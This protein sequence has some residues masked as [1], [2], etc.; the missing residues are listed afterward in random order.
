MVQRHVLLK[1]G[2]LIALVMVL[3]W[4]A[5]VL[6]LQSLGDH[7][8][9]ERALAVMLLIVF[10][11]SS[12]F[13]F[14]GVVVPLTVFATLY[15]PV[16]RDYGVPSYQYVVS[17]LATDAEEATEFLSLFSLKTW[18]LTLLLPVTV[19]TFWKVFR[20]SGFDPC[21]V[22]PLIIATV[23]LMI[24]VS[25]PTKFIDHVKEAVKYARNDQALVVGGTSENLWGGVKRNQNQYKNYVLVIG[26]SARRD[27]FHVYGYPI[28]NTPF[29]DSVKGMVVDGL[30]AGDVYTVGSLRLMLTKAKVQTREPDYARTVVGL[31]KAGG[32]ATYWFSNQGLTGN[33]DS[34]VAAIALQSEKT[35]FTKTGDYTIG[36][37]S[38][39]RLLKPL[40][41]ALADNELRSRFIVLHT[42]GS[43]PHACERV[44]DWPAKTKTSVRY[45][46]VACYSDSIAK[47]DQFLS[48]V[49]EALKAQQEK[50]GEAF[51]LLYFSDHGLSHYEKNGNVALGNGNGGVSRYQCDIPLVRINS[52][53]VVHRVVKSRKTGLLFTDGLGRWLGLS[54]PELQPYDLF[55][56]VEDVGDYGFGSWMAAKAPK[57]D[58]ALDIRPYVRGSA[59]V[60]F[61]DAA[62]D[63]AIP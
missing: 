34:P 43:H 41:Q 26:E 4:L 54:A 53:D 39:T 18:L 22:K 40:R 55:D 42:M 59:S 1:K 7:V 47:T 44:V 35:I 17:L 46:N 58:P 27:Y 50:T 56:G 25:K 38:D 28:A 29:L 51:S 19:A 24:V 21:R 60:R 6:I 49:Y 20:K 5:S 33:H 14:W 13:S 62:G 37:T 31:A 9:N 48:D 10:C 8:R 52:D 16:G 12:K 11:A 63:G 3:A 30:A 23:I 57:E 15:S 2:A 45:Q 36:N 32:F 61:S